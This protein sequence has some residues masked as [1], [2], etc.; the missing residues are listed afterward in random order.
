MH[1]TRGFT[2]AE[3]VVSIAIL[4]IGLMGVAA[5]I[6]RTLVS[7][8]RA[9]YLNIASVL[10]SEKLDSLD[11][12]PTNDLN[13]QIG[14]ALA[15]PA[16]CAAGDSYCDQVTVSS[17]S[18]ADYETQTQVIDGVP[19][20]TTVIHTSSGC[21]DTPAKCGVAGAL[22]G[23]ATFTRRWLITNAPTLSGAGGAAIVA[24]GVRRVTV[25]VTLQ[26]GTFNPPVTFQMSMVRP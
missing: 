22:A 19:T 4:A 17:S 11:K 8:T 1:P 6:S 18:G 13:V 26:D 5:L 3:V 20:T 7:G 10:A 12:W 21:V 14:G 23:G 9:R 24:N 16:A 15:G 2:M 25:L